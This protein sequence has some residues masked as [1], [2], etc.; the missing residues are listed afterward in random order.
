MSAQ[1]HVATAHAVEICGAKPVFVDVDIN[2]LNIDP[3][4][5]EEKIS[6][7]TKAILCVNLLGNP[8]NF[9][10][11]KEMQSRSISVG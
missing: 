8:C 4:K 7:K 9:K 10:I 5:I 6:P 2:T 1:T 3:L 11:I